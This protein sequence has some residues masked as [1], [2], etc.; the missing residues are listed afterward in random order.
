MYFRS[1]CNKYVLLIR[2]NE[3]SGRQDPAICHVGAL[4]LDMLTEQSHTRSRR[5]NL[6]TPHPVWQSLIWIA[7]ACGVNPG[8]LS[9]TDFLHHPLIWDKWDRYKGF[10]LAQQ[11]LIRDRRECQ[12]VQLFSKCPEYESSVSVRFFKYV[13]LLPRVRGFWS[14]FGGVCSLAYCNGNFWVTMVSEPFNVIL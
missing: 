2:C 10:N 12:Y 5:W 7:N 9:N 4:G 13:M 14:W 6:E 8:Y 11:H 3:S 1:L